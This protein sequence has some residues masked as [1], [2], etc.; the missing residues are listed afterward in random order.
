MLHLLLNRTLKNDSVSRSDNVGS[1]EFI[2]N[3]SIL[4]YQICAYC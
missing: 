1:D 3:L 2:S 4:A